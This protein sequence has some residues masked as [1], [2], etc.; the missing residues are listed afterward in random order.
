MVQQDMEPHV[1]RP[2]L[3]DLSLFK[4]QLVSSCGLQTRLSCPVPR[5]NVQKYQIHPLPMHTSTLDTFA[6]ARG[7]APDG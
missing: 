5:A 7:A 2:A 6:F 3:G 1:S 4:N